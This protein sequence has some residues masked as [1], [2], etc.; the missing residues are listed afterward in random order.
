[1]RLSTGEQCLRR[2][3]VHISKPGNDFIPSYLCCIRLHLRLNVLLTGY[4]GGSF[5]PFDE[6]TCDLVK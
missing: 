6:R 2:G 1:M 3:T 5:Q 4:V